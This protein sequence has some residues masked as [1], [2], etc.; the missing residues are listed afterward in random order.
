MPTR[1]PGLRCL[2]RVTRGCGVC[3]GLIQ[4]L[5]GESQLILLLGSISLGSLRDQA[6]GDTV[7]RR[8]ESACDRTR[9]VTRF[10]GFNS[11]T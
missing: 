7:G 8:F 4:H 11:P 6:A 1:P 5:V 2:H 3:G 10:Y 9:A